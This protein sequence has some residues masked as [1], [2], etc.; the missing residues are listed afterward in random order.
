MENH[1]V[2]VMR[3][4]RGA[5]DGRSQCRP[6]Q[7]LV[8]EGDLRAGEGQGKCLDLFLGLVVSAVPSPIRF[9]FVETLVLV[10]TI[11]FPRKLWVSFPSYFP[12]CDGGGL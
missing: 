10:D 11:N 2:L 1:A 12:G 7:Q 9:G 8:L 4:I 3:P 5:Y 6:F